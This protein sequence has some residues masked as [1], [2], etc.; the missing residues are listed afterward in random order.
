[1]TVKR[2]ESAYAVA[3]AE[4]LA[5]SDG[6]LVM[7]Q[8]GLSG[9]GHARSATSERDR[10][11]VHRR[12]AVERRRSRLQAPRPTVLPAEAHRARLEHSQANEGVRTEREHQRVYVRARAGHVSSS[13]PFGLRRFR[14]RE[15]S[16]VP[17][18]LGLVPRW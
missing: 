8:D 1:V 5:G 2:F 9:W 14:A 15:D 6:V 7:L 13:D 3:V 4:S 16:P 17:A 10:R 12:L 11:V 18:R